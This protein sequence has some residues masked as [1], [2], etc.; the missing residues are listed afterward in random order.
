[1]IQP[2]AL[3]HYRAK[4]AITTY[5]L[6]L[7]CSLLLSFSIPHYCRA[8]KIPQT[9]GGIIDRY[10]RWDKESGPY[11]IDKDILIT[12]SG[13]LVITPGTIIYVARK[14]TRAQHV[15]Q[16]DALDS[17]S[18]AIKV[19]GILNCAGTS[20]KP[21]RFVPED[22]GTPH[23][24]YGIIMDKADDN[25][26]EIAYTEISGAY[27]AITIYQCSPII[28]NTLIEFNHIGIKCQ[29]G[30]SARI[31]NCIISHNLAA[32]IQIEQ[33]N[34]VIMNSIITFNK[35]NGIWCDG[36]SQITCKYTCVFGNNDGNYF[37]CDP[38]LGM[39]DKVNKN[40]DTIDFAHNLHYNPVFSGSAAD[41][42]A[43]EHDISLPTRRTAVKDTAYMNILHDST[44]TP[45][46]RSLPL[47]HRYQLSPYSPCID[48]GNPAHRFRDHDETRNDMGIYGGP[49]SLTE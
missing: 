9:V 48:A 49:F 29:R 30:G 4:S 2:A 19:H 7:L 16:F 35:N 40:N 44:A 10:T 14:R 18:I 6:M 3:K 21:I 24:W 27:Q 17:V 43:L 25:V 26:S 47:D 32:G 41:S 15:P 5:G 36:Y 23:S 11:R 39:P 28:R 38:R 1:M 13:N 37:D 34:P 42:T 12:S 31:Y 45:P 46:D 8:E 33:A 20:H 22:I